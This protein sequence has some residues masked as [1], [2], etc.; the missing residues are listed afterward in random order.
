MPF[1]YASTENVSPEVQQLRRTRFYNTRKQRIYDNRSC[2]ENPELRVGL[3]RGR[4]TGY[5]R[6]KDDLDIRNQTKLNNF[7]MYHSF[8][9]NQPLL[10]QTGY[11][12]FTQQGVRYFTPRIKKDVTF[13]Q[14]IYNNY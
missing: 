13:I 12:V 1:F 8:S 3:S 5:M 4:G 7:M 10:P 2:R 14:P 9:K 6:W 11:N